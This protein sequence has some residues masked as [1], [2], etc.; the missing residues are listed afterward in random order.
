[1]KKYTKAELEAMLKE[2]EETPEVAAEEVKTEEEADVQQEV[3]KAFAKKAIE[4]ESKLVAKLD[5]SV[6]SMKEEVEA[7]IKSQK[8]AMETKSGAFAD[9][10][11][12]KRAKMNA[13]LK[14]FST[15]LMDG[16]DSKAKEMT[17]DKS[18]SPYAGYVVDSEL[19]A[20]IRDL[21]TEY[22]V[23][24]REFFV[25][26]L[27]KGAYEA[28]A[29]ATDVTVSWVGEGSAIASTH[30]VLNQEELKLKKLAA[31]VSLT[32]ELIED[33][34]VDLFSFI[35][36]RVAEG[37]ARAEDKAFFV[38]EG[39]GDTG[40]GE[41]EGL[42]YN[43]D[44]PDVTLV[45]GKNKV[46]DITVEDI[47]K[48]IDELP[49]GAQA[50]AKF[51]GH[52]SIKNAVRLMKD[53]DGRY[54][55]QDPINNAGMPTLAGR[56]FVTVEVMP[57]AED[58]EAGLPVLL[59]GDLKKTAILGY[60][61]DIVA[62]RFNA[63]VVRNVAGNADINLITTD[64]EAIRWVSRVGYITILPTACVRLVLGSAS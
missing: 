5:E 4:V 14:D 52:R 37:F 33:Q 53:G 12:A 3:E 24:R 27:S 28:N 59:Y 39:S 49:E 15:A 10:I 42:C 32:R 61:K 16:N 63:G 64:R 44:I 51:Y 11:Q 21:V 1:M 17:T 54:I 41:F 35:A 38:G 31:I 55:Y 18:G 22:G 26:P 57:K 19:S 60:K 29:L 47:Y 46:A 34:E 9:E 45:D 56:P 48:M 13:Y 2:V 30:I 8:E 62:D 7:W 25:T 50:N 40:N 36:T 6:S 43:D 23:A 58:E 20:E